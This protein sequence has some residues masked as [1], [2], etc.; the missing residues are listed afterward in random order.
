MHASAVKQKIRPVKMKAQQKKVKSTKYENTSSKMLILGSLEAFQ[1]IQTLEHASVPR[2]SI[3]E[4]RGVCISKLLL[5]HF[6]D[7]IQFHNIQE[8]NFGTFK[9]LM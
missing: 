8:I 7:A 5:A 4:L 2:A 3:Q 1:P 9:K 6:A